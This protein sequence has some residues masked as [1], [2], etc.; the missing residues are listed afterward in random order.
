MMKTFM[1]ATF[2]DLLLRVVLAAVLSRTALGFCRNLV[3]MAGRLVCSYCH[4]GNVLSKERG[5]GKM[6]E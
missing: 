2:T 1:V 5:I 4:I 3:R 6:R